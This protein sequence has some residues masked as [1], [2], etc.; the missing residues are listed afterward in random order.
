VENMS[1]YC[2]KG[3]IS[4]IDNYSDVKL[5]LEN[6]KIDI[7]K[8]GD[9][10]ISFNIFSGLGGSKESDRLDVPLLGKLNIDS[11]LSSC[12]DSGTP[13]VLEDLDTYNSKEFY[14]ISKKIID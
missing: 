11:Y 13:Y 14:N 6:E 8:N 4:G 3:K 10:E 5:L 7:N 9:F 1:N 12:A 2:V